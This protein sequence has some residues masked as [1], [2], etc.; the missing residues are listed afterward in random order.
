MSSTA[1]C[2]DVG[3]GHDSS[4]SWETHTLCKRNTGIAEGPELVTPELHRPALLLVAL[5]LNKPPS[6]LEPRPEKYTRKIL[7]ATRD[8]VML[9]GARTWKS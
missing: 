1:G 6:G 8:V 9:E 3:L 7:E 5:S 2:T 4:L